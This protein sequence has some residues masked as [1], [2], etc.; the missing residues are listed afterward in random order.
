MSGTAG[1]SFPLVEKHIVT[2]GPHIAPHHFPHVIDSH[3]RPRIRKYFKLRT[4]NTTR[5]LL[6]PVQSPLCY[7]NVVLRPLS[8]D[9]T[10][11]L[12]A[13]IDMLDAVLNLQMLE[14]LGFRLKLA[15]AGQDVTGEA[16]RLE[17]VNFERLLVRKLVSTVSAG[18]SFQ[19]QALMPLG[20]VTVQI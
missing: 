3:L 9:I 2:L 8:G 5:H 13:N 4:F 11:V 1:L 14:Q 15:G 10:R 19:R 18:E 6:D 17:L 20:G 7:L 12:L 16:V